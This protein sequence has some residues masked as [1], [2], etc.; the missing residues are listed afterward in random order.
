MHNLGV[1]L[2]AQK[3]GACYYVERPWGNFLIYPLDNEDE[4]EHFK[5]KGGVWKQFILDKSDRNEIQSKIFV[6]F[7][8]ALVS[9][10]M[11]EECIEVKIET[12]G[13]DFYD[14]DVILI[15]QNEFKALLLTHKGLNLL[16]L[17]NHFRI[18]KG[19][20]VAKKL[21]PEIQCFID[22]LMKYKPSYVFTKEFK[23]Q[24]Y[25]KL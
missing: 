7:G 15:Q 3:T 8:A 11:L 14:K 19:T 25:V 6:R 13:N 10:F 18:Y 4:F 22:E 1:H 21:T 2:I 23:G 24:N 16:F 20:V 17:D 12:F 5:L 9:P